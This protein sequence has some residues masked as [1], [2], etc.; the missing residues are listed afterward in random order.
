MFL[1]QKTLPVVLAFGALTVTTIVAVIGCYWVAEHYFFDKFFYQ[2]SIA[3]GYWPV[4][5]GSYKALSTFGSRGEDVLALIEY[6]EE[7]KEPRVL[8]STAS[9]EF[10]IALFGDSY[11]WGKGVRE[12]QR[13]GDVLERKLDRHRPTQVLTFALE[14]DNIIDQWRK[15]L[16]VQKSG[17]KVDLYVFAIVHNDAFLKKYPWYGNEGQ[18]KIDACEGEIVWDISED[19]DQVDVGAVYPQRVKRSLETG[20]KNYCVVQAL[21][22]EFP[23]EHA[24]YIDLDSLLTSNPDSLA[25]ADQYR[26]FGLP[27]LT[28]GMLGLD[29]TNQQEKLFVT[30]MERHPSALAHSLYAEGIEKLLLQDKAFAFLER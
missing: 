17:T 14:G 5:D 9:N 19:Y 16:A 30:K 7:E 4:D 1:R 18:E 23:R 15:Y 6:I 25:M 12:D 13:L 8:G 21:L 3:H 22:P 24:V 2:K 10:T 20:T 28:F 27:V 29:N 11:I 26:Q